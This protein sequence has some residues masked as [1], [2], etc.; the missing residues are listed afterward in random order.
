MVEVEGVE[1]VVIVESV[2]TLVYEEV[3]ELPI[4]QGDGCSVSVREITVRIV[5][6]TRTVGCVSDDTKLL[7]YND[8]HPGGNAS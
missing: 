7:L 2:G 6:I 1:G 8:T 4:H 5:I 3:L